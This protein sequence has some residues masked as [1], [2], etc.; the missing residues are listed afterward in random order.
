MK[1]LGV[2]QRRNDFS[3]PVERGR[4]R[5]LARVVVASTIVALVVVVS[6]CQQPTSNAG[7]ADPSLT[8]MDASFTTYS[9]DSYLTTEGVRS[10]QVHADTAFFYEE[11]AQWRLMGVRMTVFDEI[12]ASQ[13]TVVADSGRLTESTEQMTAWGNV[14]VELPNSSCQIES[15]ELQYD[16]LADEI[17]TDKPVEFRQ[18]DRVTRGSGFTSD[19]EFENFSIRS[20]VGPINICS[21]PSGGP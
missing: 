12:G 9:M 11:T 16:P 2:I 6:A 10:G 3:L 19:L 7:T 4:V 5:A 15:T 13:A 21:G 20:P 8:N 18:G 17:R 14:R 1:G